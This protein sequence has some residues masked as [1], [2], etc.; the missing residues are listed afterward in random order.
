MNKLSASNEQIIKQLLNI[1]QLTMYSTPLMISLV[2]GGGKTHLADWLAHFFKQLGHKVAVTT[3]TK[4]YLPDA[5]SFD[6]L[7]GLD[8]KKQRQH[9]LSMQTPSTT[10]IYQHKLASSGDEQV[11]VKGLSAPALQG[12]LDSALFS[13]VIVE[14]DGA[15][16]QPIKAPASHEPCIPESSQIVFGVTGAEA[17]FSKADSS[18]VHRWPEFSALTG[19]QAG[20]EI[21]H[22]AL[23]RLLDSPQGLFKSAPE[24]AI[25]IW[26]INKVDM[27]TDSNALLQLANELLAELP[28][29][30]NIWLTQLNA[31]AAIK[32][33][34]QR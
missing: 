19:C 6:N 29:L 1:E 28:G 11:K 20:M 10:F 34:L 30:N 25:K 17:I 24:Q 22:Q 33:V 32:N 13:V 12:I 3:T 16:H 9:E 4:M 18:N 8:E 15:K 7:I 14:A 23:K 27:S 21:G 31:P 5:N 2:G 26:V